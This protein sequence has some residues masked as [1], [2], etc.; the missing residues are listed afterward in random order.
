[1]NSD[2]KNP[3]VSIVIPYYNPGDEVF[4]VLERIFAQ[5]YDNLEI[6]LVNDGSTNNKESEIKRK[7]GLDSITIGNNGPAIGRNVGIKAA[8]GQYVAFC[9]ADDYWYPSKLRKQVE[10]LERNPAYGF[11]FTDIEIHQNE[12]TVLPSS[13]KRYVIYQGYVFDELLF[14]NWITTSSV[15]VRKTIIDKYGLY[16]SED[17]EVLNVEDW[18]YWKRLAYYTN[19]IYL[20]EVMVTRNLLP[21][22][23]NLQNVSRQFY[24]MFHS[25]ESILT[26]LKFDPAEMKRLLDKRTHWIGPNQLFE[27]IL[28]GRRDLGAEKIRVIE[29]YS[30]SKL[31]IAFLKICLH[32]PAIII[33]IFHQINIMRRRVRPK[34][35]TVGIISLPVRNFE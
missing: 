26:E 6:I 30:T 31:K 28:A 3:L 32:L 5:D 16:F 9:D 21:T 23:F 22:S 2:S 20:D 13:K 10:L 4:T 18:N 29:K 17:P 19:F 27:D 34:S 1:M 33:R 35:D 12:K 7:F 14:M 11:C 8:K 24:R 15:M 25:V